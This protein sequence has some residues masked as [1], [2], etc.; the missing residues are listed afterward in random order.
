MQ[1]LQNTPLPIRSGH[2]TSFDDQLP[3]PNL[4]M[5]LTTASSKAAALASSSAQVQMHDQAFS[6]AKAAGSN[7]HKET[8]SMIPRQHMYCHHIHSKTKPAW[9]KASDNKAHASI[10]FI[11]WLITRTFSSVRKPRQTFGPNLPYLRNRDAV[12]FTRTTSHGDL[13]TNAAKT[14]SLVSRS[15]SH[16]PLGAE[17]FYLSRS[18]RARD[19]PTVAV[20]DDKLLVGQTL[21]NSVICM[22]LSC[23]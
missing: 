18:N 10:R 21:T 16:T 3:R 7:F 19:R 15:L 6:D 12:V 9:M 14:Q 13:Q 22:G 5:M 11:S 20:G 17:V 4:I 8:T 1:H 2:V 23:Y